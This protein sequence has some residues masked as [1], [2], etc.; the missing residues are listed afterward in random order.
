MVVLVSR[1]F[2]DTLHQLSTV[3]RP[4]SSAVA[5]ALTHL[6]SF[7]SFV[8]AHF[9]A[10]DSS[11]EYITF[12]I[13]QSIWASAAKA[14]EAAAPT[15]TL[16]LNSFVEQVAESLRVLEKVGR[17]CGLVTSGMDPTSDLLSSLPAV[18]MRKRREDTLALARDVLSGDP[19]ATVRVSEST[20]RGGLPSLGGEKSSAGG[21]KGGKSGSGKGGVGSSTWESEP[22]GPGAGT[23][24]LPTMQVTVA[25]QAVI[26]MAYATVDEAK[27]VAVKPGGANEAAA[28]YRLSRDLID[29]LRAMIPGRH[30][31]TRETAP[32]RAIVHCND[33]IYTAWHLTTMRLHGVKDV[34]GVIGEWGTF[35]DM[36]VL[37]RQL[38]EE[39]WE[40]ELTRQRDTLLA[41]FA[42]L[43]AGTTVRIESATTGGAESVNRTEGST[44]SDGV[45]TEW[46]EAVESGVRVSAHQMDVISRVWK[47]VLPPR[48]YLK[49]VGALLD[50]VLEDLETHALV[51]TVL[52]G[53]TGAQM[54]QLGN[55]LG[56]VATRAAGWFEVPDE[57]GKMRKEPIEK[58]ASRFEAFTSATKKLGG[59]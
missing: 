17:D 40:S 7:T 32:V 45:T 21:S 6:A 50:A 53:V 20:E 3:T 43:R 25:A 2:E 28:L 44:I 26:E 41:M 23:F 22:G 55:A 19:D 18:S 16:D 51:P 57:G 8:S 4:S 31:T 30:Q 27:G 47:N 5:R 39:M 56:A 48:E 14:V 24:R 34:G 36:V 11:R 10:L 52:K 58:H 13:W 38:A 12:P 1:G 33:C 35:A 49:A 42:P 37:F 29:L 9:P 46:L 54:Y 59:R 15:A